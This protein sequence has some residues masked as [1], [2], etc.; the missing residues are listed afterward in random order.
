MEFDIQNIPQ[1]RR[2]VVQYL[3]DHPDQVVISGSQQL[4]ATLRID[5]S[6]LIN[7]CKDLGYGGYRD[8]KAHLRKRLTS[9]KTEGGPGDLLSEF[10]VT[11]EEEES[12]ISS[13]SSDLSALQLTSEK[14]DLP[15][16]KAISKKLISADC[17]YIVGLG[18][19]A[20]LAL[21]L[22]TLLKTI[23]PKIEAIT[24]YHGD[25]FDVINNLSQKDMVIGFSFDRCMKETRD[26]FEAAR[27]QSI[28]TVAITDTERSSLTNFTE[29][30]LLIY[31]TTKFFFSPHVAAFSICNAIMH[32][33]VEQA[34]PESMKKLEDYY[35]MAQK[36][37]VYG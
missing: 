36:G 26:L 25:V 35:K 31:N 23:R 11:D 4:A 9:F 14:L 17:V 16:I 8:L 1:K 10:R 37:R 22:R 21:Y 5:R 28:P 34:K 32:C 33:V 30:A 2:R 3:L 15:A 27:Q 7:A 24:H 18:Y 12:V 20:P 6:T 19:L 29:T 13:I